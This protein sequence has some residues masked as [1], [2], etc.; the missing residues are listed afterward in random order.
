[1]YYVLIF[2][3]SLRQWA[4]NKADLDF[5]SMVKLSKAVIVANPIPAGPISAEQIRDFDEFSAFKASDE[6]PRAFNMTTLSRIWCIGK[7]S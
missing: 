1:M 5:M 6:W 3:V 7:I 2:S 4:G